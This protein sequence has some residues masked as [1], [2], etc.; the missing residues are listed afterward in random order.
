M[1]MEA[2]RDRVIEKIPLEAMKEA[3]QPTTYAALLL[4][5]QGIEQRLRRTNELPSL[6]KYRFG[7]KASNKKNEGQQH[8]KSKGQSA[9]DR[10]KGSS[11]SASQGRKP[12]RVKFEGGDSNDKHRKPLSEIQ[13]YDCKGYRH[14]KGSPEC[15]NY[16]A[17]NEARN[18]G[19]SKGKDKA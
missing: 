8:G 4:Q 1:L 7:D 3:T 17:S 13:C 15:P 2:L 19:S 6:D 10:S 11:P 9:K 12:A 16:V 18:Q 5:Y 14:F